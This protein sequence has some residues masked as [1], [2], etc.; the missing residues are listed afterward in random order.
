MNRNKSVLSQKFTLNKRAIKGTLKRGYTTFSP[1]IKSIMGLVYFCRTMKGTL[2][3]GSKFNI[4][5][6]EAAPFSMALV[7][8]WA[9]SHGCIGKVNSK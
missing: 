7:F 9:F 2:A 3:K 4:L 8:N 5:Q 1:Y 6:M